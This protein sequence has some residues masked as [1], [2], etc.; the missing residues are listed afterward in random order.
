M[1][2][3][4]TNRLD[5]HNNSSSRGAQN[6]LPILILRRTKRKWASL[7]PIFSVTAAKRPPLYRHTIGRVHGGSLPERSAIRRSVSRAA[8]AIISRLMEACRAVSIDSK[9]H[10]YCLSVGACNVSFFNCSAIVCISVWFTVHSI[11]DASGATHC[12]VTL[13]FRGHRL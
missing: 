6:R 3:N 7:L 9:R 10:G 11:E 8:A 1:T 5:A 12:D 13:Y 2:W 4:G